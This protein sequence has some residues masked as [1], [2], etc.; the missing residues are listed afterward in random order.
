M[1]MLHARGT[2]LRDRSDL[3]AG[4]PVTLL[5]QALFCSASVLMVSACCLYEELTGGV[6]DP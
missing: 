2:A 1:F 6:D 3:R 5:V 4:S